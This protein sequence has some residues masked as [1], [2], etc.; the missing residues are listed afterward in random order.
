MGPIITQELGMH[1]ERKNLFITV[2]CKGCFKPLE[3]YLKQHNIKV[4]E[5]I[6]NIYNGLDKL[7]SGTQ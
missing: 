6:K 3:L 1:F 5:W 2:L 7:P 4:S